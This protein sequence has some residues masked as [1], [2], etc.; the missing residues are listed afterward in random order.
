MAEASGVELT[1]QRASVHLVHDVKRL[2]DGEDLNDALLDFFVK[3]GQALIPNG[4]QETGFN[5]GLSS[6]AYLGSYF[7]G[8]LQKGHASDGRAGHSN[9]ANWAKRRLGKGG[10]FADQVGAF[11]VPVNELLRDYMGRQQEKHWW[12]AVL[13]NP[14]GGCP[15]QGPVQEGVSVACLDSFARTGMRYKPPR[16]ALKDGTI[17]AYSVEISSFSRSGFVALVG[18]RAQGDGS[19]GPLVDP[20]LSRLQFGHRII[21][22]PELDLKVRNY[23]DFGVP[24]VLE[25]TLE[26]AF[27]SSTRICGDYMLHY[28]GVAEYKPALKLELRREPNQSQQQVSRLLAGYCGKEWETASPDAPYK[29]SLIAGSLQLPDTPQQESAH[30]CG[31]FILEQVLRLLQLTPTALRSLAQK[32]TEDVAGLPWPAQREVVKRKK[33]LREVTAD[34]FVAARRQGTG[35][36]EALLKQDEVLRKKLLLAMWEGPYF[37]RA[38]ANLIGMDPGPLPEI[39]SLP[40]EEEAKKHEAE[41]ESGSDETS[42]RSSSSRARSSSSR[43][44]SSASRK[45]KQE[46]HASRSRSRKRARRERKETRAER[47]SRPPPPPSF[48]KEDLQGY[49]SKTLRNLCVQYKVLPPGMVERTDLLK[50]LER[51]AIVKNAIPAGTAAAAR[52]VGERLSN[53]RPDLPSFTTDELDTMPISKLKMFCIQFGRLP[54]GSL[55]KSDLKKALAPLAKPSSKPAFT[56]NGTTSN[57]SHSHVSHHHKKRALPSFSVAELDSMP[58][59]RLKSYCIQYGK[60]PHGPVERTDLVALLRP[61]AVGTASASAVGS[62]FGSGGVAAPLGPACVNASPASKPVEAQDSFVLEDLKTMSMKMLKTFCLKHKVMPHGHTDKQ[63]FVSELPLQ[64]KQLHLASDCSEAELPQLREQTFT[65]FTKNCLAMQFAWFAPRAGD[66]TR[67]SARTSEVAE[68]LAEEGKSPLPSTV[69]PEEKT[70]GALR[71]AAMPSENGRGHVEP[72]LAHGAGRSRGFMQNIDTENLNPSLGF[73][74][75]RLGQATRRGK[76]AATSTTGLAAR[77]QRL[78]SAGPGRPLASLSD[79][80]NLQDARDARL[81]KAARPREPSA[82]PQLG[83]APLAPL[84]ASLGLGAPGAPL[85]AP[86]PPWPHTAIVPHTA[87]TTVTTEQSPVAMEVTSPGAVAQAHQRSQSAAEYVPQIMERLFEEETTFLPRPCYMESQQDINGKM[88]AILV[89]WLVEVHMKYRLRPETLFLAVNLIDRH[90]SALPVLRRRLQLVGVAGM[91]VAAKFE[92]IDP[93]RATDFVY[94]TDNTYSKEELL[95][96]ECTMLSALDFRVVVPTPAHFFSQFVKANNCDNA[97]H[98]ET[99]KYILEL[100]LIDLRMIRYTPSHLLAAAVLLSNDL[101]SRAVLWPDVMVQTSRHTEDEL[102]GCVE[103]LRLLLRAAPAGSL[104]AVRKKYMLQQYHRVAST[105]VL[106]GA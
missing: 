28:G 75:S 23:G 1:F 16:R 103:E 7:Y 88:R 50:A 49:P 14:R 4:K 36:V 94:I 84:G 77:S 35:D 66:I 6:V 93:P 95:Q 21:K 102:R 43:S 41:E 39:P 99:I 20:R 57:A 29:D 62:A 76:P 96:M 51:L 55:E 64:A 79:I 70:P 74:A 69:V 9:V 44:S 104:Q 33:K 47:P 67:N 101:F 46:K 19:L 71:L 90:M 92:E 15:N 26:F 11:A 105:A 87:V 100:A 8:M 86:A 68:P 91:F 80:T 2:E 22:D 32:S 37:A 34:L 72:A 5:E 45:R 63:V 17:E 3:L 25:G 65:T 24:G 59:S 52:A 13:V 83:S 53:G 31:F 106:A 73:G 58:I 78:A 12:L 98:T 82:L 42:E 10:L 89:D 61:F 56:G 27:D 60:M 81:K 40:K 97:R 85:C 30:D 38:V 54:S 48:T 18:F